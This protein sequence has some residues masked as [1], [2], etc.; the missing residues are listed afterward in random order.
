MNPL[1]TPATLARRSRSPVV[2]RNASVQR[3]P[4]Q[5]AEKTWDGT[6]VM[7]YLVRSSVYQKCNDAESSTHLRAYARKLQGSNWP[8]SA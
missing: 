6:E 4:N 7:T 5:F 3:A 2:G 8:D 1:S